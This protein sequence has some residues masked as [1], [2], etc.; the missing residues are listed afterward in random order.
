MRVLIYEHLTASGPDDGSSMY[1]EGRAMRDALDADLRAIPGVK[2]VDERADVAFVIAPE[3][4]GILE[5][6]VSHF[7]RMCPVIAPSPDALALTRDKLALAR[8]WLNCNVPT[9]FTALAN[10]WPRS[11]RPAVVKPRDGAGSCETYLVREGEIRGRGIA[12]DYVPG[13]AASIVFLVG[14]RQTLALLPTFQHL[15]DDG[16]FQYLGGELPIPSPFAKRAIELGLRAIECVPGLAGYI[17]VD[18]ILGDSPDGRDDCAI[19]INPRLTMSYIGLRALAGFNIA[20]TFLALYREEQI[21]E[22][23]WK[24]GQ[25]SF[26]SNG[27]ITRYALDT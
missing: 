12:Q 3:T 16:R 18:L 17:G 22:L 2:V 25:I 9:P 21:G 7:R 1:R 13:R 5:E 23:N 24:T 11:R 19:E 6:R 4:D 20:A 15:S 26:S 27:A 14:L 10:D 8:H